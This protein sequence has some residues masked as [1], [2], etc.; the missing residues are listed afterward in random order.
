M[1]F[2]SEKN[3]PI[4]SNQREKEQSKAALGLFT[5]WQGYSNKWTTEKINYSLNI[6][7]PCNYI[8][9]WITRYE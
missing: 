5:C 9:E 6:R 2:K 8:K 7:K 1:L 4:V 3:F